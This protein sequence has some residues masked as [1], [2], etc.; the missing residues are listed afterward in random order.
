MRWMRAALVVALV[1]NG[2]CTDEGLFGPEFRTMEDEG[3]MTCTATV[4]E[5]GSSQFVVV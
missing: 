3:E 2:A 5:G 4:P 1:A